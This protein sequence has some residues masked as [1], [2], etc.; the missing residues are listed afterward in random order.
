MGS[1]AFRM[2]NASW[3]Q[4]KGWEDRAWF[5]GDPALSLNMS[6][7]DGKSADEW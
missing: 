7:L 3:V 6:I 2:V 1:T 4:P 5:M